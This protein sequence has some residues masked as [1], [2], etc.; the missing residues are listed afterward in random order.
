METVETGSRTIAGIDV[1][2]K[3]L[4]VVVRRQ[5]GEQ[6]IYEKRKFGATRQEILHLEAW[7]RDREVSEVA[8]ESTAQYWRPVWYG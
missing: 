8:M 4:A 5:R 3:M 1:H 6:A 7:L 2:K